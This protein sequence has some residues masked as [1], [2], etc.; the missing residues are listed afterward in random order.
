MSHRRQ[1]QILAFEL[2][3]QPELRTLVDATNDIKK[4][5]GRH[6]FGINQVV[7]EIAEAS[8]MKVAISDGQSAP[9]PLETLG[10][11]ITTYPHI[12][13]DRRSSLLTDLATVSQLAQ[14]D[15][16]SA[17]I[18]ASFDCDAGLEQGDQPNPT[19]QHQQMHRRTEAAIKAHNQAL[20][21][22]NQATSPKKAG[23]LN[24]RSSPKYNLNKQTEVFI[25]LTNM[26][27]CT[28]A[29]HQSFDPLLQTRVAATAAE[30]HPVFAHQ[31]AR[32]LGNI[33]SLFDLPP[34]TGQYVREA[35]DPDHLTSLAL[36]SP[37]T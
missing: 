6:P 4:I 24:P 3:N 10:A 30:A 20:A 23:L 25:S 32:L 17:Q 13:P 27:R 35:L 29:A 36:P 37:Q 12:N 8:Q 9:K 16:E 31:A 28:V 5:T 15:L 19:A 18:A 34:A 7:I 11:L 26:H 33:P 2:N 14:L 1:Y 22:N 21:R